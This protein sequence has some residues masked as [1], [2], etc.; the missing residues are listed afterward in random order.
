MRKKNESAEVLGAIDERR[1]TEWLEP[2]DLCGITSYK[3]CVTNF[4]W[5]VNEVSR[6]NDIGERACVINYDG[7]IAVFRLLEGEDGVSLQDAVN[8][9]VTGY[10]GA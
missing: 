7:R 1:V 4:R 6:L 5:C 8:D 9:R 3:D 2:S 10:E